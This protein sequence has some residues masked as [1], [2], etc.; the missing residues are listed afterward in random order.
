MT[1]KLSSPSKKKFD[2][3][4]AIEHWNNWGVNP[5]RPLRKTVGHQGNSKRL[6]GS[7]EAVAGI[8]EIHEISDSEPDV[9]MPK[10]EDHPT[11]EIDDVSEQEMRA[12]TGDFE[13]VSNANEEHRQTDNIDDYADDD[14][15][16]DDLPE[17]SVDCNVYVDSY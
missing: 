2:P 8:H 12:A 17:S 6:T 16:I 15:D 4:E 13:N 1:I 7:F 10:G 11:L 5:R 3:T 9:P 14:D